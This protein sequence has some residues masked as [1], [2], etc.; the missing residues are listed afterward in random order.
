MVHTFRRRLV[1]KMERSRPGVAVQR[2]KSAACR[3][4]DWKGEVSPRTTSDDPRARRTREDLREA[5]VSLVSEKGFEAARVRDLTERARVNRATFYKHYR[6][7]WDLLEDVFEGAMADL[8]AR[9]GPPPEDTA[10]VDLDDPP[11]AWTGL[12]EHLAERAGLYR[13]VLGEGGS[14]RFAARVRERI[15]EVVGPRLREMERGAARAGMPREVVLAFVCHAVLGTISWWL[16]DGRRYPAERM[17]GW[18]MRLVATGAYAASGL[19][20]PP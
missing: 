19:R 16:E 10:V 17:A 8:E 15:E 5:L 14:P 13:A 3:L 12:F 2:T 9:M 11:D 7:K 20:P 18:T 1:A 4:G 6:D